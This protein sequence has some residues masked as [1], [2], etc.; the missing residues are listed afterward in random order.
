[1]HDP[2][3]PK[4]PFER[5]EPLDLNPWE[6]NDPK[7]TYARPDAEPAP[8]YIRRLRL[9]V[10]AVVVLAGAARAFLT[11]PGTFYTQGLTSSLFPL[12]PLLMSTAPI[13]KNTTQI[14]V[15][16]GD[17]G[18]RGW[19]KMYNKFRIFYIL[20]ALGVTVIMLLFWIL[21]GDGQPVS[22]VLF[23]ALGLGAMVLMAMGTRALQKSAQKYSDEL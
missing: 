10:A 18:K 23:S 12:L 22:K 7:G 20:F 15:A 16:T 3:S 6:A 9:L 13:V 4:E 17:L 1:M 14:R 21:A 5:D 8:A 11:A 2:E 19:Q